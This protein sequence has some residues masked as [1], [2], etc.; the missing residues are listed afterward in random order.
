[1]GDDSAAQGSEPSQSL[2][3]REREL[4][5][6]WHHY[7][8]A[9]V[10]RSGVVLVAG[11]PGIGKSR[12]LEE[13]AA[14]TLGL[15][16]IV[17]MGGA[18][19]AEGMP[20]YLPFLEALGHY[21]RVAS[22]ERLR[23]HTRYAPAVLAAIFP[24]LAE[25]LG[26]IAPSYPLP[27]EQARLRLYE[28]VSQLLEAISSD[29]TLVL[30]LDD[31]Q[32]A[33]TATLELLCFIARHR[34]RS[35]DD[36]RL[37]ILGAY[38]ESELNQSQGLTSAI[39]ELTR[40]RL[41]TTL[42][43]SQLTVG[44]IAALGQHHLGGKI[45]PSV[46]NQLHT[47]SEGNPFFAEELLRNWVE[48]GA[49]LQ[50]DGLWQFVKQGNSANADLPAS[51]VTA[52]GQRLVRLSSGVVETLRTAAILGRTFDVAVLAEVAEEDQERVEEHLQ[53]AMHARL[54]SPLGEAGYAFN[55]DKIREV[56][57]G[58]VTT[59]RRT[60]LHGAIGRALEAQSKVIDAPRLAAL[61]FHFA[62]SGERE[63]GATYA[64]QA[65]AQAVRMYAYDQAISH[66]RTALD[67]SPIDSPDREDLLMGL[68]EAA[69]MSSSESSAIE[70]YGAAHL[71][72]LKGGFQERAAMAAHGVG[73]ARWRLEELSQA[74][75]AF[76]EAISLLDDRASPER[77]RIMVD[78]GTLLT[79]SLGRPTEGIS[80]GERA[81]EMAHLLA[82]EK[83]EA[84]A[85]RALGNMLVRTNRIGSGI[86]L[87]ESALQLA[88]SLGDWIEAAECCAFLAN[89]N[90]WLG[91]FERSVEITKMRLHFA[92]RTNDPYQLRH[93]HSWLAYAYTAQGKWHEAEQALGRAETIVKG[94]EGPEPLGF[95]RYVRGTL[96][97]ERGEYVAA[98][99][100]CAAALETFRELD[101][102]P[103]PSTLAWYIGGLGL[104][105]AFQGNRDEVAARIEELEKLKAE[106]PAA[107]MEAFQAISCITAMAA[108]IGDHSRAVQNYSQLLPFRNL[109]GC[110]LTERLLGS[111]A[112][113]MKDWESARD[114]LVRA[115]ATARK[116]KIAPELARTLRAQAHLESALGKRGSAR[117]MM[118]LL[119]EALLILEELGLQSAATEVRH[120][121]DLMVGH[122]GSNKAGSL[123]LA[124]LTPREV[125]VLALVA[126][127]KSNRRIGEE[128][129]LSARTV[130]NHLASIFSKI[131]A[132][133][134][135]A[136]TAFAIRHGLA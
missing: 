89:A 113:L 48:S 59:T 127:G 17:L 136:A 42:T 25:R 8:R 27:P 31:L 28:A 53:E 12:L 29:R 57:Y 20:P 115:E 122:P 38:R 72:F 134:R 2:V 111:I 104:A 121:L 47:Q 58:A 124:G 21:I 36:A 63:R 1:M 71:G 51:M 32:W 39:A 75:S 97:R 80:Y 61:A 74:L 105:Q 106:L 64:Q 131:G 65:A 99:K 82:D 45:E 96:C 24:E 77:V 34:Q 86:P 52:I 103:S 108:T 132:E 3:G 128:L 43:L 91:D 55:H 120:E 88:A 6:L 110:V 37:L 49:L 129:S 44:E 118:D 81:L 95:L 18:S 94:L 54:I 123:L 16:C 78:L 116:N 76:E 85:S 10:G 101:L 33:D 107:S 4:A 46:S 62:R 84:A 92:E 66:Y 15:G 98:E 14:R 119:H 102:S 26:E 70:A 87:L 69:L 114:H 5:L 23:Q 35:K 50:K 93:V 41:L 7:E 19:Q 126:A 109:Y 40:Q 68:G 22:I 90:Y 79:V 117:R 11:E 13:I 112:T 133:N 56:L 30:I 60:R 67:L 9:K 73:L 83:L 100:A 130:E 125:E 135:A